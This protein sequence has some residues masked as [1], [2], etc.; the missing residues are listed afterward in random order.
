MTPA[1]EP[2]WRFL[3]STTAAQFA[4]G[5][6]H[7]APA[8]GAKVAP[9]Y[10]PAATALRSIP[11]AEPV[12]AGVWP[13]VST[14]PLENIGGA[15]VVFVPA[16]GGTALSQQPFAAPDALAA[17]APEPVEPFRTASAFALPLTGSARTELPG[18][19][20]R[21]A[22][23][24]RFAECRPCAGPEAQPVETLLT[25]SAGEPMVSAAAIRTQPF[26][27]AASSITRMLEEPR[28][29]AAPA[30]PAPAVAAA[31]HTLTPVGRIKVTHPE[32]RQLR[33]A[34]AI[35][36]PGVAALEYHMQSTRGTANGRLEWKSVR[37]EPLSPRFTL[38]AILEKLD[39]IAK[40]KSSEPA[41]L[42]SI[43]AG[44]RT[45]SA[46]MEQILRVAAAVLIVTT[47]WFTASA[48][49]NGRRLAV[50]QDTTGFATPDRVLTAES[51]RQAK[52]NESGG[53]LNWMRK[54][55][56]NRASLQVA[57]DFQSG[58]KSW[59]TQAGAY[60][61]G[62]QRSPDGYVE[63]GAIAVFNPTLKF[64]DYRLEF[65][66]QIESKSVGWAVRARD[67]KNYHA[68]K[69]TVVEA[70]LRPIIA[71]VH[72]NV[73]D[74][75]PGRKIQTPL[76]VMVHN[77]QPLQ[78][79]VNVRGNHLVTSVDGEEVDT[80]VSDVLPAGGVGFFSDTGERARLYWTRVTKNDDWLGHVCAF[81]SGGE[82]TATAE[83]WPPGAPG[84]EPSPWPPDG[85]EPTILA[86]GFGL[87]YFRR[88]NLWRQTRCNR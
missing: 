60:P 76:N 18:I 14:S 70:G 52:G 43:A 37:F 59:G 84:N 3:Q 23:A 21:P 34:P 11:K 86:A 48:L 5:V 10:V 17:P 63:T 54:T 79:T 32:Q 7:A 47:I 44:R 19:M 41:S 51:Q 16:V 31:V 1:A 64:T 46:I 22:G 69:F 72:Y 81:L 4:A 49:R 45:R 71:L 42:F 73:I 55:V 75:K 27:L 74:G 35:P 24:A 80:F 28:V 13:R 26:S 57:D 29:S 40:P 88:T 12:M 39:D 33:P 6:Q 50:R 2:V 85:G 30:E 58:M 65:F 8:L 56:A 25:A 15:P 78:V 36:R 20:P 61:A 38:R 83:L 67:E 87:P 77:N 53:P 66:S 9:P 62:W 68:M 82:S